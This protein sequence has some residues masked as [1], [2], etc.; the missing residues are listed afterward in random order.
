MKKVLFIA[1]VISLSACSQKQGSENKDDINTQISE[2]KTQVNELNGK[3][4]KLEK[5]V[6]EENNGE[7]SEETVSVQQKTMELEH[8]S[9]Y[10]EATGNV[11]AVYEAYISPQINGQITGIFVKEGETIKK[12]QLLAKL[13]TEITD[14][15]I[16]E[17][18]TSLDLATTVY[19]KQKELWDKNIGSE[20]D[21][22]RAKNS[23]ETL[24]SKL[25]TLQAQKDMATLKS[26][27]NG[28]VEKINLKRG[29]ISAPGMQFMQIVNLDELYVD[30]NISDA[31]LSKIKKGDIIEIG[32]PS[33]PEIK[34]KVPVY[35]TGNVVNPQNRTFLIE[36]KISNPGHKLKPNML[37]TININDYSAENT[38]IVPS[39]IVK[40]DIKGKFLYKIE[41]K[42]GKDTARKVYVETG[43][44]EGDKTMVTKGLKEGDRIIV[45]GYNLVTDGIEVR[46]K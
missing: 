12:G 26:P 18:K 5:Q 13:N 24:E 40:Q 8:F 7:N 38:L 30:A 37:A 27:I 23:K 32:F 41:K 44:S 15:T 14:N 34:L 10:F 36:A 31:Y 20:I 6:P 29:E 16:Q 25:K 2:Y 35:R 22:L 28:I 3:I 21:Y 4:A 19:N 11:K 45:A 33:Y 9:H 42:D 17:V 46:V 1:A 39:I 43:M